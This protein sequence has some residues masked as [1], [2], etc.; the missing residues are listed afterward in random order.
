LQRNLKQNIAELTRK[1]DEEKKLAEKKQEMRKKKYTKIITG[2]LKEVRS[3]REKKEVKST[4]Q[5]CA[6]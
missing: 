3:L 2:I 6:I 4:D 1:R 5:E